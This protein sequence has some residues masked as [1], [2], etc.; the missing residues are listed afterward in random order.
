MVT[1]A[2]TTSVLGSIVTLYLFFRYTWCLD[3]SLLQKSSLL[4]LSVLIGCVP[5][6]VSYNMEHFWDKFYPYYRYSLYFIFIGCIILFTLTLLSDAAFFMLSHTP[7]IQSVKFW[8]RHMN[9]VNIALAFVFTSYALYAGIKV[10]DIEKISLL[11][12]QV[13][14]EKRIAVLSDLHIHRVINPEKIRA[15]VAKTNALNPDVILLAGDIIDDDVAKV[16]DITALLKDLKAKEGV[17]FVTGNHEFYAGYQQTVDELKKLGFT[18]LENSGLSLGDIYIAGI[19][20]TFAGSAYGKN[21]DIENAF[22]G[23]IPEQFRLLV[24]H[25]PVSF[26]KENNFDL[27]VSGHTHGGQIFP[28]HIFAKLHN[29][30]LAGLYKMENKAQIYVSRGAGQWGPQMRFLAPSEITLITLN[31]GEDKMKKAAIDTVF[32]QGNANPYGK[33]FTGQTYLNML[34]NNDGV[35]NAPIGNVTF[36]PGAKTNWHKHT[37]GQI[38]LVLGGEGRYQERGKEIRILRKGDIVRIAPDVEHW[39]GAAPESW[40][41]HLSLETNAPKNKV[42][43]LEPVTAGEYK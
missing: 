6:F 15:I 39:H 30:Y 43:W 31:K 34:S 12:P 5:L 4:A 13:G 8:C 19:P 16:S 18:F 37:G 25:T 33:F 24:S 28:F 23:A 20:D 32:A 22:S 11:S 2:I 1:C 36:E 14:A 9:Y 29:Q 3:L 42:V 35:F 41:T 7:W 38:L 27:E 17:Y 40:F 10:P 21:V 26:G